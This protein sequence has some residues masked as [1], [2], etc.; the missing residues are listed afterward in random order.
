MLSSHLHL[1]HV[2][3]VP[4]ALDFFGAISSLLNED[5]SGKTMIQIPQVNGGHT[6][7]KIPTSHTHTHH[8]M[9]DTPTTQ[10]LKAA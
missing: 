6:A 3:G 1:H 5:D 2:D 7:F 10:T 8:E 9:N 4:A